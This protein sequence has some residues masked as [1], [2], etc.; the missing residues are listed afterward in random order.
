MW[1]EYALNNI[2]FWFLKLIENFVQ[3]LSKQYNLQWDLDGYLSSVIQLCL[4]FFTSF[5]AKSSENPFQ[6]A[7]RPLFVPPL[8]ADKSSLSSSTKY[9]QNV[10]SK[11]NNISCTCQ[12]PST[13]QT[14]VNNLN[15]A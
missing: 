5:E 1:N 8:V 15:Y 6:S 12:V 14:F 10:Y 2:A 7:A 4:N 9:F 3:I 11:R 13:M